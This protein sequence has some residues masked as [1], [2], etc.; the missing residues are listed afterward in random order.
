MDADGGSINHEDQDD[1]AQFNGPVA[2]LIVG[3]AG[4]PELLD[5]IDYL[6]KTALTGSETSDAGRERRRTAADLAAAII[7]GDERMRS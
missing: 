6:F 7:A 3:T 4:N 5:A 1:A 2:A